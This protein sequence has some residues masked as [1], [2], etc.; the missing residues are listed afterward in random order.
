MSRISLI[1]LDLVIPEMGGKQRLQRLLEINSQVKVLITSGY[2]LMGSESDAIALGAKASVPKP[3]D[4]RQL[5]LSVREV[6]DKE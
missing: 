6:L 3:Y 2:S 5:L 1:I 4:M